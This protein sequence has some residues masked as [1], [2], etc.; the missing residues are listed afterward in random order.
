MGAGKLPIVW[1]LN[2]PSL[3]IVPN[4]SHRAQNEFSKDSGTYT[5]A[6]G[7]FRDAFQRLSEA[8]AGMQVFGR[9]RIGGADRPATTN[10]S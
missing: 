3:A 1:S 10:M 8:L 5:S 2:S 9:P 6:D 4:T 7:H